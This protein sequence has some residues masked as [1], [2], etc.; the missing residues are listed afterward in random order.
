MALESWA[1]GWVFAAFAA[2]A[3]IIAL[4]GTRLAGVADRLADRTGMGEA[5]VGALL[6]GGATSLPGLMAT[7]VSAYNGYPTLAVSNAIGGITVQTLWLVIG[8]CFLRK[9]NL[10]HAAASPEIMFQGALLIVLLSLPLLAIL[11]PAF[12]LGGWIH[13]A[14]PAL[15]IVW[16]FGMRMARSVRNEP[17]WQPE[18][19]ED[20]MT[21]TPDPENKSLSLKRLWGEFAVLTAVLALCGYALAET[22]SSITERTFLSESVVGGVFTGVSSSI[23][24]LVVV[25][26]SVRA[27]AYTLAVSNIVGGNA[28]DT[29]FLL[30][31]DMAYSEGSIYHAL[32]RSQP[33]FLVIA[34][35]MTGILLAGL[36]RRQRS[37]WWRIG[38]ESVLIGMAYAGSIVA[39]AVL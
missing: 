19:T 24:E 8:D 2:S 36:V 22:A 25:I 29:L 27:G 15:F 13:P 17:M 34:I 33:F 37:G 3:A 30:F 6:V 1:L 5:V 18:Q 14:S 32:T 7:T 26:A 16:F 4:S 23:P 31:A 39:L 10:E 9:T 21:D 38:F 12:A 20:T 35:F 28:L 11:G